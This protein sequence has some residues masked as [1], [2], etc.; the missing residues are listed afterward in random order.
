M[1]KDNYEEHPNNHA[2][3]T[4]VRRNEDYITQVSKENEGRVTKSETVPGV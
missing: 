3:D 4:N 1:N 2:G